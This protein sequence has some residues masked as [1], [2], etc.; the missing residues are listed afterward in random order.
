MVERLRAGLTHTTIA[1]AL[2]IWGFGYLLV[3]IVT[4][5]VG[6]SATLGLILFFSLPM[7]VLG[8]VQTLA[9]DGLRTALRSSPTAIRWLLL[10]M[11]ILAAT[12]VQCLFDL[13]W[14]RW[15]A[16]AL[17]PQWQEWA[18]TI[19]RQRFAT[20]IVLALWTYSLALTVIWG[21]R[22]STAAEA[23]SARAASAEA[24]A[25]KAEA[26]ALRL[27]LNP[28]FMFNT[29]NSISSLILLDRKREAEEMIDRLCEFLRG[30]LYS[31]PM[32]DVPLSQEIDSIDAYLG[33][34]SIRFE[35]LEIDFDVEPA[36][37]E[38]RVPN[39]ILQR[40]VEN[41]IKHGVAVARGPSLLGVSASRSGDFLLLT[42]VNSSP[43]LISTPPSPTR[44]STGIG[45]ANIRQRLTNRYGA[46]ARL[47]TEAIA[48]GYRAVIRLPF[49]E[50]SPQ[51][52]EEAA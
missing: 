35:E 48:N 34:E 50:Q 19:N 31:D 37:S 26:A 52:A 28:H 27:Q 38:A 15:V 45:I 36:A 40:L 14:L 30:S 42:V 7:L 29:L 39:C 2:V 49:V 17:V 41:A 20:G 51:E 1:P 13:Y 11:A 24:A 5:L 46:R 21:A 25:A 18:L 47:D 43:G 44:P 4:F 12:A 9:I 33:I 32:A 3:D 16:T 6:R 23:S 22:V 8:V 10:V